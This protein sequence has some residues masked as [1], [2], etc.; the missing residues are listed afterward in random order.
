M[1]EVRN[2]V[3]N[4]TKRNLG[5]IGLVRRL[6]EECEELKRII[7]Y[8]EILRQREEKA[9]EEQKYHATLS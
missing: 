9:D 6:I 5:R 1:A 7:N 3:R 2:E 4:E 8:D